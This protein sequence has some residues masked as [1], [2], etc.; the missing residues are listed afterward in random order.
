M[1]SMAEIVSERDHK[2]KQE[3]KQLYDRSAREKSLEEGKM[4]LV[5]KPGLSG[6]LEEV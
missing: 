5:R 3:M 2:A 6:K 1:I 4:V